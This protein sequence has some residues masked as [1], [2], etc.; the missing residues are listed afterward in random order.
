MGKRIFN[1]NRERFVTLAEARTN[2]VL[3]RLKVLG[4]CAN[5]N[6][7]EYKEEEINKIFRAIQKT[8]DET[9][10]KFLSHATKQAK[11]KL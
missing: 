7:Y 9:R 6:L 3:H 11:F 8:I 10:N 5:K 4:N 1:T 2:T